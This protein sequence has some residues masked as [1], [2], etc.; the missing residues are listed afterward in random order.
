MENAP[1]TR[2][3]Q[4]KLNKLAE[5]SDFK[6]CRKR[7]ANTSISLQTCKKLPRGFEACAWQYQGFLPNGEFTPGELVVLGSDI[8]WLPALGKP[9]MYYVVSSLSGENSA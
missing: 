7:L 5:S 8:T 1:R 2:V 4:Q 3:V 6:I 9:Q